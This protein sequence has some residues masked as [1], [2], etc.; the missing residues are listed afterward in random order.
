[1]VALERYPVKS[2]MG[3]ALNAVEVSEVGL[4]GDRAYAIR[5]VSDGK[6]ASAKNPRKWPDMFCFRAAFVGALSRRRAASAKI[7]RLKEW[8]GRCD[9]RLPR[10]HS[11]S[12]K[13]VMGLG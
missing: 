13:R 2:M 1:M 5:D 8:S 9:R 10:V 12:T 4:L 7:R 3:E 6:I 11:R